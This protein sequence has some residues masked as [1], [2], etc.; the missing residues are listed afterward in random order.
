MAA[1]TLPTTAVCLTDPRDVQGFGGAVLLQGQILY[2]HPTT[3]KFLLARA[4]DPIT[5]VIAGMARNG[6][7]ADN[8]PVDV[9]NGGLITGLSGLV[10]GEIYCLA[11]GTAGALIAFSELVTGNQISIF[12]YGVS[13]T[14][15]RIAI[16]NTGLVKP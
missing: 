2:K 9:L 11:P 6:V 5:T 16:V 12:G 13:A 15:L 8:S 10:Q 3:Q 7:G 1:F 4:D 14:S